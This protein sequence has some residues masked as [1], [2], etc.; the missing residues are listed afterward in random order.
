[1][2]FA[3]GEDD[4]GDGRMAQMAGAGMQRGG[5]GDLLAQVGRGVDEEPVL[6]IGADGGRGHVGGEVGPAVA[7]IGAI[8][9][10]A[11]PLRNAAACRGTEYDNPDHEPETATGKS[12]TCAWRKRT[13]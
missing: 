6:A 1:V 3:I 8:G 4:A 10:A 12:L 13:C 5:R 11:V 7:R 2:D 9:A